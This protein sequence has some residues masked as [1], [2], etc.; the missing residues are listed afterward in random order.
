MDRCGLTRPALALATGLSLGPALAAPT[1]CFGE[2][3]GAGSA[4]GLNFSNNARTPF[5]FQVNAY[6]ANLAGQRGL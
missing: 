2:D 6:L 1:V 4:A 3:R 5:G